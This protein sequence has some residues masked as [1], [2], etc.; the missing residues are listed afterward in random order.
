MTAAHHLLLFLLTITAGGACAQQIYLG[1]GINRSTFLYEDSQGRTLEGMDP[2]VDLILGGGLRRPFKA[3][4]PR[5]FYTAG[6]VYEQYGMR[7]TST[8]AYRRYYEWK[9][10]YLGLEL[11]VERDLFTL[12]DRSSAKGVTFFLGASVAPEFMIKGSQTIDHEVH[13]LRGIEQ[14]DAPFLFLRGTAGFNYCISDRTA[15]VVDYSYAHGLRFP[16][17]A[18]PDDE[19]LAFRTHNIGVGI[20]VALSNCKYCISRAAIN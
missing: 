14:F 19:R 7:G 9:T 1:T 16:G 11:G 3:F 4:S 18:P 6:M 13:D 17:I 12:G 15:I 2:Q 8:D 5:W 10:T 20:L